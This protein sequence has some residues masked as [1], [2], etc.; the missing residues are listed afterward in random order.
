MHRDVISN[1]T[2]WFLHH[3][4]F[5]LSRRPRFDRRF[6]EAWEGYVAV[7]RAFADGVLDVATEGDSVL[8]QDYQLALVPH[9]LRDARPDLHV[10][11]FTHT[12]FCGP[13]SIRVL[14]DYVAHA[15][16]AS[17][18]GCT[19]GFHTERW[20]QSFR[21][22]ARE[23]LGSDAGVGRTFAASFGPDPEALAAEVASPEVEQEISVLEER[24]GDRQLI[25]RSDRL[26]LSKNIVRGFLAYDLMLEE[27][28]EL[29]ERVTFAAMLNPS[30]ESLPEYLA[31]R[32]EVEN[33]AA[34]VNERWATRDWEPVIVDTRDN[35]ARSLAGLV[36][37]DVLLVNPIRDGLNLVAL[38]GPLANRRDGVLC[39][40]RD[41]GAHEVLEH[42]C[43]T[44]QP[45]DLVQTGAAL[46]EALVMEP[47]G[48]R[49]AG[50]RAPHP[51]PGEST[52]GVARDPAQAGELV[53]ASARSARTSREPGRPVDLHVGSGEEVRRFLR[54]AHRD[55]HRVPEATVPLEPGQRIERR[56]IA[57][58]VTG[59]R[60]G[61]EAGAELPD[62]I[63]LVDRDRRAHLRRH[64]GRM[65]L[66]AR[67]GGRPGHPGARLRLQIGPA[68]PVQHHRHA[69]L[70]LDQ[71]PGQLPGRRH[72]DLL[73]RSQVGLDSRIGDH[74]AADPTLQ[75]VLADVGHSV[76]PDPLPQEPDRPAADHARRDRRDPPAR[77]ARH[78]P[79]GADA[80][81][82][83]RR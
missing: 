44:V 70:A 69:V 35:Y 38:E 1:G 80:T 29:R 82:P 41:A 34:R 47:G 81:R 79:R 57:H 45:F 9:M 10:V 43:I 13:G 19:S 58:V 83:G 75:P 24:V 33:T 74:L 32:N 68:A 11:H 66:E 14:P 30:R 42:A 46:H 73:D 71:Q 18:A 63:A 62:D 12:P 48:A 31:Y 40:S 64:L 17:M 56:E 54:R 53:I 67:R 25:V 55:A 37:S 50:G 22:S 72:G 5:D 15:I 6:R 16:C 20:A 65:E 51:R 60:G 4:L 78:A 52:E 39:L 28:P 7:N 21:A 27:H 76:E 3:A 61:F 77:P 23:V 49:G 59:E 8:V 26:E 2:L 36:R